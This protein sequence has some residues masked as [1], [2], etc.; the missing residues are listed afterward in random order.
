[1]ETI[2]DAELSRLVAEKVAGWIP[3]QDSL[4]AQQ[5]WETIS[6][7]RVPVSPPPYATSSDA[8]I[9]L[10]EK[11]DVFCGASM[12]SEGLDSDHNR[13]GR[14]GWRIE[15]VINP[16]APVE[17]S[18]GDVWAPTFARAAC[19]ALLKAAGVEVTP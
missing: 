2:S 12:A 5:C 15:F 9:P 1:M 8:V 4:E 19:L 16:N 10:L 11:S 7:E 6:G 18:H 17:Q 3:T 14:T 13:I